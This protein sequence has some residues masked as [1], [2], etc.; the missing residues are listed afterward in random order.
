MLFYG[1]LNID[2]YTSLCVIFPV[3]MRYEHYDTMG[4]IWYWSGV[5]EAVKIKGT[6]QFSLVRRSKNEY[7]NSNNKSDQS[8]MKRILLLSFK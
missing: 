3:N 2:Y 8:K 7:V 5:T 4:D 6:L 1:K